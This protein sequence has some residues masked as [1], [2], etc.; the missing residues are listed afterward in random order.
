MRFVE[1][2]TYVLAAYLATGVP[3]AIRMHAGGLARLD[4]GTRGAGVPFRVL[5]TPGLV[6]LWPYVLRRARQVRAHGADSAPP[7]PASAEGLR[8]LHRGLATVFAVLVPI[9]AAVALATRPA[10]PGAQAAEPVGE[11]R[12]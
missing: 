12:R 4:P 2:S 10:P 6:A 7:S 9:L 5:I 1:I 3:I 11:A 8:R